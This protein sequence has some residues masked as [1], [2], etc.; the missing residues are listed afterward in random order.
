MKRTSY[1]AVLLLTGIFCFLQ[2]GAAKA[3]SKRRTRTSKSQPAKKTVP[4][5]KHDKNLS[6]PADELNQVMGEGNEGEKK[7]RTELRN[8]LVNNFGVE[9][10]KAGP[11]GMYLIVQQRVE[12]VE[13]Q[14][15]EIRIKLLNH[16][17]WYLS[18]GKE[19]QPPQDLHDVYTIDA[20]DLT[21]MEMSVD[22]NI[23]L[24]G[25]LAGLNVLTNTSMLTISTAD[26]RRSF[27]VA[28]DSKPVEYTD[29]IKLY[30]KGNQISQD[31]I[32]KTFMKVV[33]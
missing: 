7:S 3:Q 12:A 13:F 20:E 15:C 11:D 22:G 17:T 23:S 18:N 26:G 1:V 28:A 8:L 21:N 10:K 4:A 31:T 33:C 27:K 19:A 16:G 2:V 14:G 24:F 30:F 6:G 5:E 29:S 25:G 9:F 32:Y